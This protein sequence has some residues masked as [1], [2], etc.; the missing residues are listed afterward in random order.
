MKDSQ[1]GLLISIIQRLSSARS[2]DDV[3]DIV[4]HGARNLVN[5]DGA[6]FVLKDQNHCYYA[7]E[8]SIAPLWKGQRFPIETC[9]SGWSMQHKEAVFIPDIYADSRV[10]HGVYRPT[11]V[12][13]LAMVPIRK[14]DPVGAIGTYWAQP[15]RLTS[16]QIELLQALADSTSMA[17]ENV[18]L[19]TSLEKRIEELKHANRVKD[20]FLMIVSHELRTPLNAIMGWAEL[21][22]NEDLGP[23]E[24]RSA[25][26]TIERNAKNQSRI[27]EDLL[28]T[29]RIILGRAVFDFKPVDMNEVCEMAISSLLVLA[30]K[31]EIEIQYD[32]ASELAFVLG[33][34]G[35]LQQV[36]V[37]L[38]NNAIKFSPKGTCIKV[39][40]AQEGPN[41]GLSVED[42]GEGIDPQFLPHVFERFRQGDDSI[43]RRH[44]GLGLGLAIVKSV[45]EAHHGHVQVSSE[46]P[47]KGSTFSLRL[48]CA[49]NISSIDKNS[50][51]KQMETKTSALEGQKL[52]IIDD[53]QDSRM[54][55]E[56]SLSKYGALVRS[57]SSVKE[58][59]EILRQFH[60]EIVICDLS[61]PEEDGYSFIKRIRLGDTPLPV[62]IPAVALTAFSDEAHEKESLD[63]GYNLFLG[64]PF[65]AN[66]VARRLRKLRSLH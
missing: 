64:K 28:D 30:K 7:D 31:K 24:V 12:K 42:C 4:R 3:M 33:D 56:T 53:E 62:D 59:L 45:I 44:G 21:L 9:I 2:L 18:N 54:V 37:N 58:A 13:S 10:P 41:W 38:L 22:L 50:S 5:A 19:Y 51:K 47:G 55:L 23:T 46:G 63:S 34:M 66:E 25:Y 15:Q 16:D 6:T 52:L 35:R 39:R 26:E 57:A 65:S 40:L 1:A 60:P 36:V 17:I 48:P 43:T 61:M 27:I 49:E 32:S 8:D 14:S 29:S 11:Y 20:E